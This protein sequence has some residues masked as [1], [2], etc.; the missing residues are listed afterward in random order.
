MFHSINRRPLGRETGAGGIR[1]VEKLERRTLLSGAPLDPFFDA[2]EVDVPFENTGR[3]VAV[4]ADEK[5]LVAETRRVGYVSRMAVSRFNV[6][7]TLDATFGAGG[8]AI[9]DF[10][11]DFDT[12]TA[13][14]VA[15][16]GRIVI[17]GAAG[18]V[19]DGSDYAVAMFNAGGTADRS[20]G[21]DG[22]VVLDL[23]A[24]TETLADVRFDSAGRV[25]TAGLDAGG[26]VNIFRLTVS[27]APDAGFG[28][29]DGRVAT[30]FTG[31]AAVLALPDRRIV[32]AARN[33]GGSLA[34]RRLLE[35][36]STDLDFAAPRGVS[37]YPGD[38]TLQPD[39]KVVVAGSQGQFDL[40]RYTAAG[41]LD[42]SFGS[43]GVVISD[44]GAGSEEATG[45]TVQSDGKIVATGIAFPQNGGYN[46]YAVRYLPSGAPDPSFGGDGVVSTDVRLNSTD[47]ARG[48]ALAPGGKLVVAGDVEDLY[49]QVNTAGVAR[50]N[51][52]GSPDR[53]FGG[54][55]TVLDTFDGGHRRTISA[56]RRQADGK[57]VVA[58]TQQVGFD[59][60]FFVARYLADGSHDPSFGDGGV[61]VTDFAGRFDQ[62]D[63]LLIQPDGRIVVGGQS[64]GPTVNNVADDRFALARYTAAG[65]PD[66][67]FDG[68]GRVLTEIGARYNEGVRDLD[69]YA[70]DRIVATGFGGVARYNPDGSPDRT[71]AIDG[72][73]NLPGLWGIAGAVSGDK[74][75]YAD[76]GSVRRLN[77][78]GSADATF[79][80]QY[81]P[82]PGSPVNDPD[83]GE[84]YT[85][86]SGMELAPDG[87]VL[88][89][90]T[91]HPRDYSD[92]ITAFVVQRYLPTG[93][94]DP[95]FGNGGQASTD[96]AEFSEEQAAGLAVGPDGKPVLIGRGNLSLNR[97]GAAVLAAR[98][99]TDGR[100][101]TSFGYGG[102]TFLQGYF[103]A[104]AAT[105]EPDGDVLV[106]VNG[107]DVFGADFDTS[108]V[109]RFSGAGAKAGA[110]LDRSV[111]AVFV[112]GT[113]GN[114]TIRIDATGGR[115]M[116]YVNGRRQTFSNRTF[117]QVMVYAGD[118]NDTV[119][120]EGKVFVKILGGDG[121]DRLRGGGGAEELYG[122]AGDDTVDGGLG[123]DRLSGG[124]GVDTV[125]Y[126]ARTAPVFVGRYGSE[127]GQS[128][129]RDAVAFDIE[130]VRGGSGDD[131]VEGFQASYGN[132]GNDTLVGGYEPSALWGGDGD[133]LLIGGPGYPGDYFR[134]GAGVDTVSYAGRGGGVT[135]TIDG[136]ANDGATG[137]TDN[138]FT[139]VENVVGGEG[140]DKITGS[141]A[142]NNL[143]GGPGDDDLRGG[144]GN[145]TL[146]GGAGKDQLRGQAGDDTLYA[147]GDNAVDFLDGG[148]GRDRARKDPDD[149]AQFVEQLLA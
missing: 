29:G 145:D 128:G 57:V 109:V 95:S 10:G 139:D 102:K 30:P 19:A 20:F 133:D 124:E 71:F 68:D 7:G 56:V 137:E 55:G 13:M 86:F 140:N 146:T 122:E 51:A 112:T 41:Q 23:G 17:A 70:G 129:E 132:A 16:D 98:Y 44:L 39:G 62:A 38:L 92:L 108:A 144:N 87:K 116:V 106:A 79:N 25:V 59:F 104:S 36:G 53:T 78:D 107:V 85:A 93:A 141:D 24:K 89:G 58:G 115:L 147:A 67:T 66:T 5:V 138:V 60:D 6:D 91:Y 88:V 80:F 48:V 32:V 45:V 81:I 143:D 34:V 130:I 15:P 94:P 11:D 69:L 117:G 1:P 125:D 35:D 72:T 103:F 126:G 22:T 40:V 31:P 111:S 47:F 105:V 120:V 9:A 84:P 18:A 49:A 119:T 77:A 118:G 27:G 123:A 110:S 28:G 54:D 8:R 82:P 52:D 148:G 127:S 73:L 100:L 26:M 46:F 61:T 96:F 75:Y 113:A 101:D 4:Q 134:G 142:D 135:V 131:R 99:T 50:Y 121:N 43:G 83:E 76:G 2:R 136:A 114:D 149:F 33:G 14:D 42:A 21:G 37:G 97:G 90:G 3:D 12:L 74:I 65:R 63:A 64:E